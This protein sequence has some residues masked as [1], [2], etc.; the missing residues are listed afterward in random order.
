MEVFLLF[1]TSKHAVFELLLSSSEES[2]L[3][4]SLLDSFSCPLLLTLHK[5]RT[6]T[7]KQTFLLWY[8]NFPNFSRNLW[9]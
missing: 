1:P 3:I 8:W 5:F 7:K 2:L 6:R 4:Y 9:M